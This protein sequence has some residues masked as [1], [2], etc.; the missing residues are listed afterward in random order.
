MRRVGEYVL[1]IG[2]TVACVVTAVIVLRSP[3][4]GMWYAWSFPVVFALMATWAW[5]AVTA[6]SR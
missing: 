3:A 6:R 1:A 5:V 2:A 4:R